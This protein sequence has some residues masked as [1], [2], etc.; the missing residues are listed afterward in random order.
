MVRQPARRHTVV[1]QGLDRSFD[2]GVKNRYVATIRAIDLSDNETVCQLDFEMLEACRGIEA[3]FVN[4]LHWVR[5]TPMGN[6]LDATAEIS[7]QFERDAPF[8]LPAPGQVVVAQVFFRTDPI[9]PWRLVSNVTSPQLR[10]DFDIRTVEEDGTTT[11]QE[12]N[13]L[14][15]PFLLSPPTDAQGRTQVT[16]NVPDP[17]VP[18]G[19]ALE[20]RLGIQAVLE[21][22]PEHTPA[23]PVF[24]F[25]SIE[26]WS[27]PATAPQHRGIEFAF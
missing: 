5:T 21:R 8:Q 13:V 9:D 19:G 4:D 27:M 7:V 25:P 10:Q 20:L 24:E 1:L 2:G 17:G 23:V 16:F 22:S 3:M 14:R 18:P 6:T 11:V 26:F 12:Y 15:G